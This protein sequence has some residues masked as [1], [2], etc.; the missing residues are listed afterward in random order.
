MQAVVWKHILIKNCTESFFKAVKE[1]LTFPNPEYSKREQM[2]KYTGR[3]PKNI[4]L[5]ERKGDDLILPFGMLGFVF[6]HRNEFNEGINNAILP[7]QAM[8]DYVSSI[9]PYLYQEE[10][11]KAALKARNGI[12]VAPCGSGKTQIALEV[13]A[14]LG[15][16][17]LWITHTLELM[18]QSMDRAKSVYGLTAKDY[19]TITG[20]NVDVGRVVTFATVQTLANIDLTKY[21]DYWQ[22]VIVDECHKAVGTPTKL[23]MFWKVVSSLSARYKFGVTATPKR[24]DGLEPAMFALLGG[25]IHEIHKEEVADTTCPVH[26]E[27]KETRFAPSAFEITAPDGT[28]DYN[29]LMQRIVSD[30]GRNAL[31]CDDIDY[32]PKPCMVL[33]DRV[34]HA[35][36]FKGMLGARARLLC[37]S[38]RK[39]DREAAMKDILEGRADVIVATYPIAKEGLD[40]PQLRSVILATP[41]KNEV[42]IVQSC[43]RVGRRSPGKEFGIVYDYVDK[44]PVLSRGFDVR[45]KIY[46]KSNFILHFRT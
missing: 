14:R 37:G 18:K 27:V 45:R 6:E 16:R 9:R 39:K 38:E 42:T 2:G 22:V 21:R 25:M 3:T 26:V 28:I 30:A 12:I 10:A 5:Y 11:I 7:P 20:G 35:I 33:T 15:M 13:A 40:I 31:I 23:M 4:V 17:M 32:C 46:K 8:F 29:R 34:S 36:F 19:G 44:S 24:A 41:T 1:R 43:G